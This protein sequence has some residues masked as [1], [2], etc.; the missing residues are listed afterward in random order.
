LVLIKSRNWKNLIIINM[1]SQVFFWYGY[2]YQSIPNGFSTILI[3]D[4]MSSVDLDSDLIFQTKIILLDYF[5]VALA[6]IV[7]YL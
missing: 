4:F 6:L 2:L 1:F 7:T 5:S 3:P